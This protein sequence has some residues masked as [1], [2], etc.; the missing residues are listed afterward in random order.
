[1]LYYECE[2]PR[3]P[4]VS[5]RGRVAIIG[6]GGSEPERSRSVMPEHGKL[7]IP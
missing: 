5:Y 2:N 6:R 3:L 7:K 1:M 4:S